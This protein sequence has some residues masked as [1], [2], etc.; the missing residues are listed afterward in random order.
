MLQRELNI[1]ILF[2]VA[3][4]NVSNVCDGTRKAVSRE[5]LSVLDLERVFCYWLGK[6]RRISKSDWKIPTGS[7]N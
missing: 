2:F 7:L 5:K 3:L 1:L 6:V 4:V